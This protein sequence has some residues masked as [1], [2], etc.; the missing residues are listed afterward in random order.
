MSLLYLWV[1]L[2]SAGL[3]GMVTVLDKRLASYNMPS[4]PAFYA[5]VSVSLLVYGTLAVI[6]TG[7][8][9]DAALGDL[10]LGVASGLC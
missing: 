3:L 8:P 4:L 6:F 7:I 5:G 10:L 9:A 1:A 2:S